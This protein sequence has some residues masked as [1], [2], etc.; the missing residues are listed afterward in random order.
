M[1]ADDAIR[2]RGQLGQNRRPHR[3]QPAGPPGNQQI[4]AVVQVHDLAQ[5]AEHLTENAAHRGIQRQHGRGERDIGQF[6]PLAAV[7]PHH[8][9]QKRHHLLVRTRAGGV[10]IGK[11]QGHR[12]VAGAEIG[13]L[14]AVQQFQRQR[15][16]DLIGELP[17]QHP[18]ALGL[19]AAISPQQPGQQFLRVGR[20]ALADGVQQ[21]RQHVALDQAAQHVVAGD[22]ET[23]AEFLDRLDRRAAFQL[24]GGHDQIGGAAADVNAGQPQAGHLAITLARPAKH[25]EQQRG[26]ALEVVLDLVVQEHNLGA[27]GLVPLQERLR[28]LT[29]V[30]PQR[31]PGQADGGADPAGEQLAL[32]QRHGGRQGQDRPPQPARGLGIDALVAAGRRISLDE[33]LHQHLGD[34]E[35]HQ[36]AARKQGG[37]GGRFPSSQFLAVLAQ[38][39]DEWASSDRAAVASAGWTGIEPPGV[40]TRIGVPQIAFRAGQPGVALRAVAEIGQRLRLEADPGHCRPHKRAGSPA[41]ARQFFIAE[42]AAHELDPAGERFVVDLFGPA[43]IAQFQPIAVVHVHRGVTAGFHQDSAGAGIADVQ[44]QVHIH[45]LVEPGGRSLIHEGEAQ[46]RRLDRPQQ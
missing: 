15:Q 23:L 36:R 25:L 29:L 28:G 30:Q 20:A 46:A 16:R 40:M 39:A 17:A 21:R 35:A 42:R 22:V 6:E 10:D 19:I 32:G 1:Q 11:S 37:H 14:V 24:I 45:R 4:I 41:A 26:V 33:G 34:E 5:V 12:L 8:L 18:V 44:H 7:G 9:F 43:Q 13:V 31:P 27:G 3:R 38:V 2:R